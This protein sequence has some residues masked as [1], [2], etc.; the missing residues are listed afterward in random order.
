MTVNTIEKTLEPLWVVVFDAD[1]SELAYAGN[2]NVY[3]IAGHDISK[4]TICICRFDDW[5][6]WYTFGKP[7]H[8]LGR[9][10]RYSPTSSSVICDSSSS[11][12]IPS[13]RVGFFGTDRRMCIVRDDGRHWSVKQKIFLIIFIIFHGVMRA[14]LGNR[15]S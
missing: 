5:E 7:T 15:Q 1:G 13:G 12:F 2:N 10:L 14:R 6:C 9:L 11:L 4:V 3:V 8:S